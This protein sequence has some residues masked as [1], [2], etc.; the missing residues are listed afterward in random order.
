[1]I[2]QLRAATNALKAGDPEPYVALIAEDCEWREVPSGRLW[3]KRAPSWRGPDQAREVFKHLISVNA[4]TLAMSTTEYAAIDDHKLIS[5]HF[6][7][8]ETGQ[9]QESYVVLT[10]NDG[11]IVDIQGSKTR[12]KAERFARRHL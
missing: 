12:R 2:V 4:G 3:W 8:G 1:M 6:W 10:I 11:K 5:S 7:I 9:L